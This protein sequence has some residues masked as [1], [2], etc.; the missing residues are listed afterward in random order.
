MKMRKVSKLTISR[1]TLLTLDP[2]QLKPVAAALTTP[3]T[4]CNHLCTE[5]CTQP[6]CHC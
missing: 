4:L 1:E 2:M 5:R 3:D 6:T